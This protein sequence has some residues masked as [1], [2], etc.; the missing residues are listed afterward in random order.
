MSAATGSTLAAALAMAAVLLA[1]G[2]A[3]R[4]L[5]LAGAR[6]GVWNALPLLAVHWLAC[7]LAIGSW[8]TALGLLARTL[9][10]AM[11][12]AQ[13]CAIGYVLWTAAR[14]WRKAPRCEG[15]VAA[16]FS[17]AMVDA[18]TLFCAA[19]VFPPLGAAAADVSSAYLMLTALLLPIGACWIMA[20]AAAARFPKGAVAPASHRRRRRLAALLGGF[21]GALS[22][23]LPH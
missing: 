20:G 3:N 7:C 1:P 19:I 6:R 4:R 5:L 21:S 10:S 15:S 17:V 22:T 13:V 8:C 14:W 2:P 23:L 9:P 11:A 16:M 12:A 18:A